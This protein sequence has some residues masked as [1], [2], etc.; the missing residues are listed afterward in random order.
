MRQD[1]TSRAATRT[2]D[3]GAGC[4]RLR[5]IDVRRDSRFRRDYPPPSPKPPG[6]ESP[7]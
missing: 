7:C 5:V 3:S 2:A 4:G 1:T 6:W